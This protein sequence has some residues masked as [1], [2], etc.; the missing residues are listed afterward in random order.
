MAD[1]ILY[2]D[3][4]NCLKSFGLTGQKEIDFII[5]KSGGIVPIEVKIAN[6]LRR[7]DYSTLLDF[8]I[9]KNC[10]HAFVI[11]KNYMGREK[12]S[13]RELFFVPYYLW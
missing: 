6:T 4:K 2:S 12:V 11:T 10:S 3:W 7:E 5:K 1:D 13:D 9:K 8:S